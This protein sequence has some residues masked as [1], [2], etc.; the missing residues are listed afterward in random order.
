VKVDGGDMPFLCEM[1]FL[2]YIRTSSPE[3]STR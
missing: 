3:A 1:G 2:F